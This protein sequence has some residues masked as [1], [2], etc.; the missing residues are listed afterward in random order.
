MREQEGSA[1]LMQRN[2]E[3]RYEAALEVP[4]WFPWAKHLCGTRS[5]YI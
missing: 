5:S 2:V 4:L 1:G 3:L